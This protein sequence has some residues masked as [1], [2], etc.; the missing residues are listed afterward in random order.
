MFA[1]KVSVRIHMYSQK[2]REVG[3]LIF[4]KLVQTQG[5]LIQMQHWASN[6]QYFQYF[7]NGLIVR[8]IRGNL[9]FFY[10]QNT[11]ETNIERGRQM[12]QN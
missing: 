9:I 2:I 5:I 1:N 4:R 7:E 8:Q 10:F 12:V 3:R 11:D 6:Q